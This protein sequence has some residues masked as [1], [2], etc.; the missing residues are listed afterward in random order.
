MLG[1]TLTPCD[2]CDDHDVKA[3]VVAFDMPCDHDS[4]SMPVH[5]GCSPFCICN[6]CTTPVVL[7]FNSVT[8]EA[9]SSGISNES[10][11]TSQHYFYGTNNSI[12]N[13][14]KQA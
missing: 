14:P 5:D 11:L 9:N 2:D 13:P 6:C 4:E 8:S 3:E 7:P 10:D 12:W 1:L